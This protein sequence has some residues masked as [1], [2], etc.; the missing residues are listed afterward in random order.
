MSKSPSRCA[1]GRSRRQAGD[2]GRGLR[3]A[4]AP[5][6]GLSRRRHD[7]APARPAPAHASDAAHRVH[8]RLLIAQALMNVPKL[9][10]SLL[11]GQLRNENASIVGPAAEAMLDRLWFDQLFLGASAVADDACVYSMDAAEA[12]L[13]ARMLTR[14]A[15]AMLLADSSKFG[16]R[17]TFL[18]T[19]IAP[20]LGVISDEGWPPPGARGSPTSGPRHRR[21]ARGNERGGE[22]RSRRCLR[23][24]LSF[25]ASTAEAPRR[26][27]PSPTAPARS[28]SRRSAKASIRSRT[29]PGE[30]RS[31]PSSARRLGPV[32]DRGR[33]ARLPFF[34]EIEEL[35]AAQTAFLCRPARP[36]GPRRQRREGRFRRGAGGR[37]RRAHPRRHGIDG[38]GRRRS[39]PRGAGSADGV[40]RSAT[41]AAPIGSVARRCPGRRALSTDARPS[42]PSPAP[43]SPRSAARR[44][45]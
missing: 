45:T 37:R 32:R 25:S 7:G 5:R 41:R 42:V 10:V 16:R 2:R 29:R 44:R 9:K 19:E 1:S 11:G 14:S 3:S 17:T 21:P 36:A 8:Q 20:P 43:C 18:V 4:Q 23:R 40:M 34:G 22:G 6:V 38:L 12:S 35:S 33:G 13:N 24:T 30:R 31:R 15:T 27:S 39:R 26:R 28:C